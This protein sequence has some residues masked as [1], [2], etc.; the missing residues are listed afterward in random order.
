MSTGEQG[1]W[2]DSSF[3]SKTENAFISTAI[4]RLLYNVC[5]GSVITVIPLQPLRNSGHTALRAETHRF[6]AILI[7]SCQTS[8]QIQQKAEDMC[9]Y[10][11]R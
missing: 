9:F 10:D 8:D 1:I 7:K 2:E 11:G 6:L 3:G 4:T 5:N